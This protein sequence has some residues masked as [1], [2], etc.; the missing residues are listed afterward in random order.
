MALVQYEVTEA[1][2][3]SLV[4]GQLGTFACG[5]RSVLVALRNTDGLVGVWD[6]R[7]IGEG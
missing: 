3:V 4:G 7:Q 5:K 2:R 1:R 6:R